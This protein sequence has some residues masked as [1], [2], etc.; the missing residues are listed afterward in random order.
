MI[1]C[2]KQYT[3]EYEY[4]LYDYKQIA[5]RFPEMTLNDT[6]SIFCSIQACVAEEFLPLLEFFHLK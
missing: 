3:L 4:V 2:L 6:K 5:E 1:N